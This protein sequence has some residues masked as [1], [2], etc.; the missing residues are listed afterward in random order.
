[1]RNQNGFSL[2]EVIIAVALLGVIA[3][4]AA[5]PAFQPDL[6][7]VNVADQLAEEQIEI[8]RNEEFEALANSSSQRTVT[9]RGVAV[10]YT[11]GVSVEGLNLN[12]AALSATASTPLDRA[13]TAA[14]PEPDGS[15][16]PQLKRV[17]VA[18][19]AGG[20]V[21]ARRSALLYPE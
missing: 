14:E 7:R 17:T 13:L 8:C 5:V 3:L 18:V 9:T 2:I 15:L 21:L 11:V 10:S 4:L 6:Y 12:P 1:M 16:D 19:S 20:T